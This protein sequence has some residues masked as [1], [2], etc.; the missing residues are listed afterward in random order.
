MTGSRTNEAPRYAGA[1]LGRARRLR[2]VFFGA[3]ALAVTTA[4]SDASA[5]GHVVSQGE[6][7]AQIALRFYGSPRFEG[8]IAGANALDAHGGSAIV[9]GQ[10]LE[11]PA[12]AHYRVKEG[13]TW[14][15]LARMFLGAPKRAATLA[16]A[17][18]AVSWVPPVENQEIEIPA[19]VA[20]LASDGDTMMGLAQ[21]YLG[22]INRAWELDIYNDRDSKKK[23]LRGDV[24]LVPLIE[25][26]LTEEGKRAARAAAERTRTEGGGQA[27]E[28]QRH[29]EA[30]IPPLLADV[31]AGRYVDAVAKGNRLLGSGELTKPQLASIHRAL[32]EAYVALDATGLAAGACT[33][34]KANAGDQVRLDPRSVSPKIRAAC[35]VR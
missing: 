17:N 12:P 33:A 3:A 24:I 16:R 4:P 32:L 18:G 15:S 28:A 34:W 14:F 26:S 2:G 35:G 21:R 29:A 10:P 8:A 11:I 25:L 27:Y 6:T 5:F 1:K 20:H 19:V 13:D 31:R 9:A 30:D 23:V 7:L 22:D